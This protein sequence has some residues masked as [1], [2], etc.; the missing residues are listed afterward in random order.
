MRPKVHKIKPEKVDEYTELMQ[1][2]VHLPQ[3]KM[4]SFLLTCIT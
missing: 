2:D 4:T 3:K 1:V